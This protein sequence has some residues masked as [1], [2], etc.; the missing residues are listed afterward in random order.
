M[1]KVASKVMEMK[2][3]FPKK[4]R[5]YILM[6]S[7]IGISSLV[8]VFY[9]Q[10]VQ[11][12]SFVLFFISLAI[13]MPSLIAYKKLIEINSWIK[14]KATVIKISVESRIEFGRSDVNPPVFFPLV[15]YEYEY[16]NVKYKSQKFSIV[17]DDYKYIF[18]QDVQKLIKDISVDSEIEIWINPKNP[19]QALINK[20]ISKEL[21]FNYIAYNLLSLMFVILG[22]YI[23]V[24][25]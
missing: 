23:W 12:F 10:S 22:I 3:I 14:L 9:M 1:E 6:W 20:K 19:D 21:I 17:D 7:L 16:Q 24:Q 18:E 25:R 15:V 13:S 8:I 5:F 11:S 2:L 4:T